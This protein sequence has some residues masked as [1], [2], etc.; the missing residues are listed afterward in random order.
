MNT[1]QTSETQPDPTILT[2]DEV[3]VI[4]A[5]RAVCRRYADRLSAA[6]WNGVPARDRIDLYDVGRVGMAAEH[7]DDLLFDLLNVSSTYLHFDLTREQLHDTDRYAPTGR[8]I[9]GDVRL[10]PVA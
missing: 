7:A 2:A 5:A 9:P 8:T 6:Q 4:N 3:A 1:D 10:V